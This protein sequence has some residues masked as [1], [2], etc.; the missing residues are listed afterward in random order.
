MLANVEPYGT[1][2][3]LAREAQRH[4]WM[5][6]AFASMAYD[7][8]GYGHAARDE[9]GTPTL[10]RMIGELARGYN[11]PYIVDNAKG[12]PFLGVD[13]R[14]IGADVMC[15]S[16]DKA[17]G[18]PTGGLIIGREEVMVPIR[19]ALGIHGERNGGPLSFGKAAYVTQDPGKEYLVG[20]IAALR[21]IRE[22]PDVINGPLERMYQI[23]Q[24]EFAALPAEML[25]G[26]IVSKSTNGAT[27]EINYQ[28]TWRDG[29]MGIPIFTIEDMYAGTALMQ[30]GMAQMGILPSIAYDANVSVTPGLGTTDED[31]N[32]LEEPLRLS[33]RGLVR[34][35]E[36]ICKHAGV[37]SYAAA[38]V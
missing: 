2:D 9:D 34:L 13:P 21:A 23:V 11:V 25:E 29:K 4:A 26:M 32:L 18:A 28:N 33:V 3:R 20:L 5:L 12:V 35:F 8:P 15:Y 10:M 22:N 1:R 24:E 14:A 37:F 38:T 17:S 27:V 31:G 6:S 19:R 30:S 36:I 7:T 16:M